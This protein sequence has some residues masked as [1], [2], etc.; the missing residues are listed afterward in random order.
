M[1][2]PHDRT[3]FNTLCRAFGRGHVALLEVQRR[4]DEAVVAA[5]CA[6]ARNGD[7]FLF[8]PFAIL[9]EGNPFE[10][11]NPPVPEGGFEVTP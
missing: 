5:I 9:V 11:F 10:L 2:A 7:E 1:L 6:V 3:N 4:A 8:T